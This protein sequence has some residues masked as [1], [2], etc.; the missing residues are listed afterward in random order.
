MDDV[1]KN[2]T[3][4]EAEVKVDEVQQ[5]IEHILNQLIDET[6]LSIKQVEV[7]QGAHEGKIRCTVLIHAGI[8]LQKG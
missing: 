1:T 8:R 6:G 7:H 2:I 5:K 3:I 4:S